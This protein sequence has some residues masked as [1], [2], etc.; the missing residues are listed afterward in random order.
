[1][2]TLLSILS[3]KCEGKY[4]F[5]LIG[6]ICILGII[7]A[8][9][10][11]NSLSRGLELKYIITGS[12]I[13]LGL[14]FTFTKPYIGII[15]FLI[16]SYFLSP[17]IFGKSKSLLVSLGGENLSWIVIITIVFCWVIWIIK[18][19]EFKF[20]VCKQNYLIIGFLLTIIISIIFSVDRNYSWIHF[21]GIIKVF[22]IYFAIINLITSKEHF[23]HLVWI[24]ILIFGIPSILAI[25]EYYQHGTTYKGIGDPVWHDNNY[26]AHLLTMTIPL[27]FYSIFNS[28]SFIKNLI[29]IILCVCMII[30]ITLTFSRSGFMGLTAVLTI[31]LLK[32]KKKFYLLSIGIVFVIGL[33]S[34]LPSNYKDRVYSIITYQQDKS[35]I[36]RVYAWE[37]GLN[38]VKQHPLTGV[39]LGNFESLSKA[40]NPSL[41]SFR[42]AHNF[43]I[44]VAGEC[45]IIGLLLFLALI[46]TSG[47]DL[48]YLKRK[49][50]NIPE[51]SWFI[52]FAQALE[53][54]FCGYIIACSF[55]SET[56]MLLLYVLIGLTVVLR[57]IAKREI[58][59]VSSDLKD[60]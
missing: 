41:Q 52:H 57:Q 51:G 33:L 3:N 4:I 46:I 27:T 5:F 35:S 56:Y 29:L 32:L 34:F 6:F 31:I 48:M 9:F 40:Y 30:T 60:V 50:K 47:R 59:E 49:F 42:T 23:T 26:F 45:G 1:M 53:I 7:E 54:S 24:V 37:A 25:I 21:V 15:I 2:Q 55:S 10:L 20:V 28:K 8:H 17:E 38:M 58:N 39:G 18:N 13:I 44:H 16:L 36:E 12:C 22:F 14:A 11:L 19:R 43:L